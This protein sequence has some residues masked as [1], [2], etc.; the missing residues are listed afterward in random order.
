MAICGIPINRNNLS[1]REKKK[2]T[3][4]RNI[5]LKLIN[6]LP[7]VMCGISIK[8][9]N[10]TWR[11]KRNL[12]KNKKQKRGKTRGTVVTAKTGVKKWSTGQEVF[13][14]LVKQSR[15]IFYQ[16]GARDPET[17]Y[18]FWCPDWL[19]IFWRAYIHFSLVRTANLNSVLRANFA[20]T[21]PGTSCILLQC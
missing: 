11:E 4:L 19:A 21:R 7:R 6:I 8:R 1:W 20:R 2:C 18:G 9:N 12:E 3:S 17:C 5:A 15:T 16:P 13:L 14:S 10:L